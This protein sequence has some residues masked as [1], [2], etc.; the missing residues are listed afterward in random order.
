MAELDDAINEANAKFKELD[1]SIESLSSQLLKLQA[2]VAKPV[3]DN[4][5]AALS[6]KAKSLQTKLGNLG[7]SGD[8]LKSDLAIAGDNVKKWADL[9]QKQKDAMKNSTTAQLMAQETYL[10]RA[11]NNVT[12]AKNAEVDIAKQLEAQMQE[13]V[14]ATEQLN[15]AMETLRTKMQ[16]QEEAAIQSNRFGSTA[17][18]A[19][20]TLNLF[21]NNTPLGKFMVLGEVIAKAA[22]AL[23]EL[24]DTIYKTQQNLGTN[25]ATAQT[26]YINA[27]YNSAKSFVSGNGPLLDTTE[28]LD[29]T[30]A[31]KTEF[32]TILD[33]AEATRI[34]GEAKQLGVSSDDYVKA[35]RAFLGTGGNEAGIR[36]RAVDQF[37]KAG[38]AGADAIKFAADNANLLAVAGDKYADSLFAAAA[39]AKKI[40]INLGD[41]EKFANNIVGDF[42]GSLEKFSELA[43][44]GI[45][46]D[47]NQIAAVSATGTDE[48]ILATLRQQLQQTGISGEELQ[49]N[50]QLRLALTQATGMDEAALLRMSGQAG[51]PKDATVPEEQLNTQKSML[52]KLTAILTVVSYGLGTIAAVLV[53]NKYLP[54]MSTMTNSTLGKLGVGGAGLGIGIGGALAGRELVKSGQ[55]GA[56][57]G[58]GLAGGAA[59]G[60]LLAA[61]LAPFT[62]GGSL[63]LYAGLAAA[64]GLA[65]GGYAGMG[66]KKGDDIFSSAGYGARSLVTP[67]GTVALNNNDTVMAGTKLMSPGALTSPASTTTVPA[68]NT[69]NVDMSKL[70]A[71]FDKLASSLGNLGNMKVEMDG[72]TV[73]RVS[74]NASSPLGRLAVVG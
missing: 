5:I 68:V 22:D 65:A 55:T 70:E 54:G 31:F 24:T 27:L 9:L 52:E 33:P 25:F 40:G 19:T 72:H 43:A 58:L 21:T 61:A 63:A 59:G 1:K 49:T 67:T 6:N 18:K 10:A 2:A 3:A 45:D 38:L 35:K 29:A 71:R 30:K 23:K 36:Q 8:R 4:S 26:A 16:E 37:R 57:I 69:V 74:L 48:E 12:I 60:L 51:K 50:R 64:G 11:Y 42:E 53:A 32:G 13:Q 15:D 56:G 73:G 17:K 41:I 47:F 14:T 44:M 46:L 66:A 34:A 20:D 28:I 7:L 39:D 62:G